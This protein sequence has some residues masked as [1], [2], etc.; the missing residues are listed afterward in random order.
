MTTELS[1]LEDVAVLKAQQ[2]GLRRAVDEGNRNT[3]LAIAQL[4]GRMEGLTDLMNAVAMLQAEHRSHG[5]NLD[6]AFAEI[7]ETDRNLE[8]VNDD[9]HTWR[10]EHERGHVAIE[11]KLTFWQGIALGISLSVGGAT[12]AFAMWGN[13]VIGD[14]VSDISGLKARVEQIERAQP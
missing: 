12:G 8:R 2:E 3:Q 6:R 5:D 4:Q 9:V 7:G 11:K 10:K 13:K 1:V 14:V